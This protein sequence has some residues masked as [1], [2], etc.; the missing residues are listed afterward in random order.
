MKKK[1]PER[2]V[3]RAKPSIEV[4]EEVKLQLAPHS[5][6]Y[7]DWVYEQNATLDDL[8]AFEVAVVSQFGKDWNGN[9]TIDNGS[10]TA[11]KSS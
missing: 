7:R 10:L 11:K 9:I 8:R 3:V 6:G 5:Y 2:Q 1:E 4:T